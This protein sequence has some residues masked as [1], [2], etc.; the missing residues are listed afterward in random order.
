MTRCA[1]RQFFFERQWIKIEGFHENIK[2]KWQGIKDRSP[3]DAYSLDVWHGCVAA[4]RQ[5]LKGGGA[6]LRGDYKRN[7]KKH[8]RENTRDRQK[9]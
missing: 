8:P 9:R 2:G 3:A 5:F 4:L 6:N 7:Q 1:Q